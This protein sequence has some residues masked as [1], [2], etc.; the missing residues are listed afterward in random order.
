[1]VNVLCNESSGYFVPSEM[2]FHTTDN[3]CDRGVF[4]DELGA[5]NAHNRF[6]LLISNCEFN[7]FKTQS[8]QATGRSIKNGDL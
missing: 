2:V 8:T 3:K 1:M 4:N 6:C 5:L 7:Q